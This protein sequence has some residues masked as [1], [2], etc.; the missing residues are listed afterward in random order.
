MYV[1]DTKTESLSFLPGTG[2]TL[3]YDATVPATKKLTIQLNADAQ[4]ALNNN[5]VLSSVYESA[6][7]GAKI[8]SVGNKLYDPQTPDVTTSLLINTDSTLQMVASGTA[9]DKINTL[10]LSTAVVSQD[11][12]KDAAPVYDGTDPAKGFSITLA[13]QTIGG[14]ATQK[15]ISLLPGANM[16]FVETTGS[17]PD[18]FKLQL[19]AT[20]VIPPFSDVNFTTDPAAVTGTFTC[21]RSGPIVNGTFAIIN[22]GT[23]VKEGQ[24][25]EQLAVSL[26][27][28]TPITFEYGDTTGG[29]TQYLKIATDGT[30][31]FKL[32]STGS[33]L[34]VPLM[35]FGK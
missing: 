25:Q 14:V 24:F 27:P 11:Y 20:S 12:V 32:G 1:T 21:A 6:T 22:A 18:D 33:R 31:S 23:G 9:A 7:T 34:T 10:G 5:V 26:Q 19:N 4:A 16:S 29:S 15:K 13:H 17:T 35:Y 30:V 2:I 3:E 8:T 28:R